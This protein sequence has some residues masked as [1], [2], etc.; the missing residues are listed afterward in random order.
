VG[1]EQIQAAVPDMPLLKLWLDTV[2][3]QKEPSIL[4]R[5]H[6][7]DAQQL[8]GIDWRET[9]KDNIVD[10]HAKFYNDKA[11]AFVAIE[12]FKNR[13]DAITSQYYYWDGMSLHPRTWSNNENGW[14][15]LLENKGPALVLWEPAGQPD[16][17]NQPS[18]IRRLSTI[19]IDK[20]M[21]MSFNLHAVR[22]DIVVKPQFFELPNL[23]K[24][25]VAVYDQV[26]GKLVAEAPPP[27]DWLKA[28]QVNNDLIV[29][30]RKALRVGETAGQE[31]VWHILH[32]G[33]T[34]WE[35][36]HR[37]ID[38]EYLRSV[39]PDSLRDMNITAEQD[40]SKVRVWKD[41]SI[42]FALECGIR[43]K[44]DRLSATLLLMQPL[45]GDPHLLSWAVSHTYNPILS[46]QTTAENRDKRD[47]SSTFRH[48]WF[49]RDEG[50]IGSRYLL[51]DRQND[52]FF[53]IDTANDAVIYM[54]G[55]QLWA[56]DM[57]KLN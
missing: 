5:L 53:D 52:F 39:L 17:P 15:N 56:V 12:L 22:P 7:L 1:S 33:A 6:S 49:P 43:Q 54:L 3:R 45:E 11:E 19:Q 2:D 36:T 18:T 38:K 23:K 44:G 55:G 40:N 29:A 26:S 25:V 31:L 8:P 28:R 51:T 42:I 57:A 14:L 35:T 24:N 34:A 4:G 16:T 48:V 41:G 37:R 9:S 30:G 32:I 13:A 46:D 20:R 10:L 50:R 27:I 21:D 47:A